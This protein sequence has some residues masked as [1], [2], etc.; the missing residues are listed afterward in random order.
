MSRSRRSFQPGRCEAWL[1]LCKT[2]EST[3]SSGSTLLQNQDTDASKGEAAHEVQPGTAFN[4][5][6][7]HKPKVFQF[8]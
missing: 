5:N 8:K 1:R 4:Q 7:N 6:D 3:R 2:S